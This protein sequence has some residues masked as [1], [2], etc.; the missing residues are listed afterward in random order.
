MRVVRS[1]FVR[2]VIQ[3]MPKAPSDFCAIEADAL[4]GLLREHAGDLCSIDDCGIGRRHRAAIAAA[5]KRYE[6]ARHSADID[7]MWFAANALHH[8]AV[9]CAK[10]CLT[11]RDDIS[12]QVALVAAIEAYELARGRD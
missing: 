1:S 11:S 7:R 9:L 3:V 5:I 6:F 12:Q 4:T 2:P 10:I 8:Q